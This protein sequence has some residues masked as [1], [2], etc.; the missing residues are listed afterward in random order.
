MLVSTCLEMRCIGSWLQGGGV[1]LVDSDMYEKVGVK[2]EGRGKSERTR[3][4][5]IK[6]G[7]KGGRKLGESE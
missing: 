7:G 5:E 4:R 3:E 1:I 2:G 6:G